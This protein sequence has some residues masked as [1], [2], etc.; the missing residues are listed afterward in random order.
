MGEKGLT[1]LQADF[2]LP[3][4]KNESPLLLEHVARERK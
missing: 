4:Q 3:M 2:Q 1:G